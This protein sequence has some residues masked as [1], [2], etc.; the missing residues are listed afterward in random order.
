MHQQNCLNLCELLPYLQKKNS[1]IQSVIKESCGTAGFKTIQRI[2]IGSSFCGKY[3]LEQ[4]DKQIQQ[5][6]S[7]CEEQGVNLT[8]VIPPFSEGDLERGKKKINHILTSTKNI[9]DE[10]TVNDYGMLVYLKKEYAKALN[11]GRLF[12]KDYRDP[13]Y[14][15]Y[16]EIPW[17]PR[18]FTNYFKGIL[19]EYQIKTCEFDLTHKINDFSELPKNIELAVHGPFCYQTVGRICEYASTNKEITEKFRANSSC[20]GNCADAL[21]R[22][23]VPDEKMESGMEYVRL[24]RTVYFEHPGYEIKGREQY[25]YIHFPLEKKITQ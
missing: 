19:K 12:M 9:I 8:L 11:I 17:K 23:S 5:V 15:E 14:K 20:E 4:S 16:F 2:Y 22:Y 7:F 24:G 10:L 18:V 25:R 21:I 3:F 13:R 6:Q 1:D